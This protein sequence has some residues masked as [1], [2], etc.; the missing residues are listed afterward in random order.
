MP[1][2]SPVP[3][4]AHCLPSACNLRLMN[5][6]R[7]KNIRTANKRQ[8]PHLCRLQQAAKRVLHAL[9]HQLEAVGA[10]AAA[11]L[12]K[13]L[14]QQLLLQGRVQSKVRY[15]VAVL[16]CIE[17]AAAVL[18]KRRPQR[19]L[20]QSLQAWG[21]PQPCGQLGSNQREETS[22]R[23][24]TSVAA[25]LAAHAPPGPARPPHLL[26]GQPLLLGPP[27]H[28]AQL[29]QLP[30]DLQGVEDGELLVTGCH[31]VRARGD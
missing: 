27:R 2:K 18:R 28:N 4:T 21:K 7:A 17:T 8:S 14:A 23:A 13:Q 5:P 10:P 24:D 1:V 20:L 11:V 9:R 15:E 25:S 29:G 26:R 31:K 3:V 22:L 16:Y 6:T 12:R 30:F 19:L